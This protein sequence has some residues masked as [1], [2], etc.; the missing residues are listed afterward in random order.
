M[1]PQLKYC[2][3]QVVLQEIPGEV[4][5]SFLIS[6]CPI[7]CAGC[8]SVDSWDA[9]FGTAINRFVLLEKIEQSRSLIT[10]VLFMGGEWASEFLIPLLQCCREFELKTALYT[11]LDYCPSEL[12]PY[13]DF[14]KTGRWIKELGG[15]EQPGTNQRLIDLRQSVCLNPLFWQA[16][17]LPFAMSLTNINKTFD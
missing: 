12:L 11:G 13:L 8:H 6:G 16:P 17:E 10:G 5:L 1:V 7:G 9:E 3:E 14:V 4:C 2:A 15:L